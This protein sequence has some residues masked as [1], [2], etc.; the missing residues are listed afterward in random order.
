MAD[1]QTN[2]QP[3]DNQKNPLLQYKAD[4]KSLA[5]N[6]SEQFR[7]IVMEA[8]FQDFSK[9][10]TVINFL[11]KVAVVSESDETFTFVLPENRINIPKKLEINAYYFSEILVADRRILETTHLPQITLNGETLENVLLG[12]VPWSTYYQMNTLPYIDQLNNDTLHMV[13]FSVLLFYARNTQSLIGNF[14]FDFTT[15]L[16]RVEPIEN[17][18]GTQTLQ[19]DMCQNLPP[20]EFKNLITSIA[21]ILV[22]PYGYQQY[23]ERLLHRAREGLDYLKTFSSKN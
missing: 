8:I 22:N 4:L 1:I 21:Q 10:N 19:I 3:E 20:I 23:R 7:S 18:N 9:I 14:E 16:I 6:D 15:Q 12:Q 17:E 11:A 5:G 13:V 2:E